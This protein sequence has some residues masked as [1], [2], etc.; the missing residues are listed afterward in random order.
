[1][2]AA[3]FTNTTRDILKVRDFLRHAT[4]ETTQQWYAYLLEDVPSIGMNDFVPAAWRCKR[5][6][7]LRDA[8][9]RTCRSTRHYQTLLTRP[10]TQM[11]SQKI[12]SDSMLIELMRRWPRLNGGIQRALLQLVDGY[13]KGEGS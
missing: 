7:I 4:V 6:I 9:N 3:L 8:G 13:F 11:D 2:R 5:V 1:M 10:D 12:R